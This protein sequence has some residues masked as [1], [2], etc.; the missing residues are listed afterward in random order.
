M[1]T[2]D[3]AT[4]VHGSGMQTASSIPRPQRRVSSPVFDLPRW[5]G[6]QI[7]G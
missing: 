3:L 7:F 6:D 2:E 1:A 4:G 5:G